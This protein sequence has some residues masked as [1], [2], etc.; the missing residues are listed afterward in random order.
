MISFME[1]NRRPLGPANEEDKG[2]V[3]VWV[4]N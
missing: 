4:V 1:S 2:D 3:S